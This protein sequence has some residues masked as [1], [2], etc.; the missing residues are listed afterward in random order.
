MTRY[1]LILTGLLSSVSALAQTGNPVID[2]PAAYRQAGLH[3]P[4]HGRLVA[5]LLRY[6]LQNIRSLVAT[7]L[8]VRPTGYTFVFTNRATVAEITEGRYAVKYYNAQDQVIKTATGRFAGLA[9]GASRNQSVTFPRPP[10]TAR[11][12]LTVTEVTAE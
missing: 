1:L 3:S 5:E 8:Q 9:P 6:E 12:E 4:E 2:S 11:T 10:D 7:Q